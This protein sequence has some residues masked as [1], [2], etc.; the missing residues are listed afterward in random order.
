MSLKAL[1]AHRLKILELATRHGVLNV[2]VFGSTVRGEAGPQSDID[3]L[4]DVEPG[5][6]LLD[7]IAFEQDVEELL[8]CSVDVLTGA[9]LSP[10]LQ[11]RI[12]AEAASL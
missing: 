10:Y 11:D 12:L 1:R 9:G 7:V 6:T 5:R 8:G 3:L 2:R 4:I